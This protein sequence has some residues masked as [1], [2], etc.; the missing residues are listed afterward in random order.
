MVINLSGELILDIIK[1][2]KLRTEGSSNLYNYRGKSSADKII[3]DIVIGTAGEWGAYLYLVQ[4]GIIISP[5]DMKIYKNKRKS[6]SADLLND[7]YKFHV[8][9]QSKSS[10]AKY[11]HSW[12]LQKLDKIVT[13]PDQNEY[14][15][16]TEVTN[17]ADGE[18]GIVLAVE[19]LGVVSIKEIVDKKL[20]GECKV[21]SFRNTKV[22]LYLKDLIKQGINLQSL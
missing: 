14:F 5:P 4:K 7:D 10:T 3:E 8:K 17:F 1:F 2:A 20:F 18:D 9:S 19:I 21:P 15:I 13:N 16:F 11:G 12:L 6:F 22:A